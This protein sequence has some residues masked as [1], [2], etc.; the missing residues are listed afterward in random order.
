MIYWREWV[1]IAVLELPAYPKC[2]DYLEFAIVSIHFALGLLLTLSQ[3]KSSY[4]N[5][6]NAVFVTHFHRFHID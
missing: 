6:Q 2:D 5:F 1:Q 3:R 4:G